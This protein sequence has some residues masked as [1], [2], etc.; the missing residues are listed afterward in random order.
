MSKRL[1]KAIGAGLCVPAYF[2]ALIYLPP[3]YLLLAIIVAGS[4]IIGVSVYKNSED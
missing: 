4:L 1:L 2:A 3:V